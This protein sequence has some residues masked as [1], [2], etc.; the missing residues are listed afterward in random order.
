MTPSEIVAYNAAGCRPGPTRTS[1]RLCQFYA[2]DCVYKDPQTA[3]GLEG[4]AA[5]RA[6]LTGLFAATPPMTYTPD[7]VWPI[8]GGF[9]GRWYLHH[10][11]GR[12]GAEGRMR[13]FDL[14]LL[15]GDRIA[16]NEVYVHQLLGMTSSARPDIRPPGAIDAAWL[17]AV[18]RGRG[19]DAVVSGLHSQAV[20]TGQIGDSVRFAPRLRRRGPMTRQ[21]RWSASSRRRARRAA[22]PASTL[23][24]YLREVRFYQQLAPTGADPHAALLVHRRGRGDQRLRADDGGPGA[25]RAGRPA[26]G[27]HPGAGAAGDG[28]RR[29]SCTPRT[30]ATRASTS[31]PGSRA[32]RRRR[33]ARRPATRVAG[34]VGRGSRTATVRA[35]EPRLGRR[36]RPADPLLPAASP[37]SATARAA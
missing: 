37:A 19:V 20:G 1:T 18:L 24:N 33:R 4:H 2:D 32:P 12:R 10:R 34:P 16:L 14:V 25:G 9:C 31:C 30:G 17:T 28:A 26:A 23:G 11:A 8:P 15:D 29:P 5:L 22:P 6:Y 27:R 35:C 13:G 3:A 21:P 36:R 7:E